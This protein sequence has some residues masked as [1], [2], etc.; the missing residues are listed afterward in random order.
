MRTSA[1]RTL[2]FMILGTFTSLEP[3]IETSFAQQR[4]N[5]YDIPM[6]GRLA[7]DV[8]SDN[9]T[10]V[11]WQNDSL[12][13]WEA[14]GT[15]SDRVRQEME[16]TRQRYA[17]SQLA[18]FQNNATKA[19]DIANALAQSMAQ[20]AGA[21]DRR[22]LSSQAN[23]LATHLAKMTKYLTS[24]GGAVHSVM[25][26]PTSV[27]EAS[28]RLVTILNDVRGDILELGR[29]NAFQINLRVARRAAQQLETARQAALAIVRL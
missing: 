19:F 21:R 16:A 20:P 6:S 12:T 2:V 25:A 18:N 27:D 9:P 3:L 23:R 8:R 5:D 14:A 15:R 7:S 11:D 4:R 29:M 28:R 24:E 26:S 17:V 22:S 10:F 13:D 1:T